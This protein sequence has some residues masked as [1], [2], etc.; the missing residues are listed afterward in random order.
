MLRHVINGDDSVV[1]QVQYQTWQIIIYI[2]VLIPSNCIAQWKINW[3]PK[4]PIYL[5][6]TQKGVLIIKP[7]KFPHLSVFNNEIKPNN[8]A[9]KLGTLNGENYGK[10]ITVGVMETSRISAMQG[11]SSCRALPFDSVQMRAFGQKC[12][13]LFCILLVKITFVCLKQYLFSI[14]SYNTLLIQKDAKV[15]KTWYTE[16]R[17]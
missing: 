13:L 12:S 5:H 15:F 9:V 8:Y 1:F 3:Y 7:S 4:Q 11:I 16:C 17:V 2:Y 6:K 10:H 14:N